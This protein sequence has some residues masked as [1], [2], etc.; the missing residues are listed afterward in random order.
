MQC[1]PTELIVVPTMVGGAQE[2]VVEELIAGFKSQSCW[3][4]MCVSD[5]GLNRLELCVLTAGAFVE[6]GAQALVELRLL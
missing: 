1:A 5:L 2:L 6:E 3:L 4:L